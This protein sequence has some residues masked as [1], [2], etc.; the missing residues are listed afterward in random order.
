MAL[1][2]TYSHAYSFPSVRV[3]DQAASYSAVRYLLEKG[4]RSIG[5]IS[6]TAEDPIAGRPRIEGYQQALSDA[7]LS[8]DD[9]KI[10]YGDFHFRSGV[11]AMQELYQRRTG[12]T[13]TVKD[14]SHSPNICLIATGSEV[15]LALRAAA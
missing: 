4:H 14:S 12:I 11:R 9:A 1:V 3:D 5:L 7:G 8:M 13:Y 6:G 2:A 15:N 10:V